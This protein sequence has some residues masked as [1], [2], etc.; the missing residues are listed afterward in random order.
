MKQFATFRLDD[1]LFG[2]EVML[3]REI[4]QHTEI[5][6][7]PQTADFVRGLINLRGQIITIL[8]LGVRLDLAAR[9]IGAKSHIVVLK[10]EDEL[11]LV[12]AREGRDDLMTGEDPV[13]LLV[14]SIGDVVVAEEAEIEPPPPNLG[15]ID[16][17]FLSSVVELKQDVLVILN[18]AETIQENGQEA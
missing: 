15:D 12:R 18:V 10:T 16:G 3:V 9:E 17:R 14:D 7:V 8:D 5:T 11:S 13:G 6:P 2:I 1:Q 4:N